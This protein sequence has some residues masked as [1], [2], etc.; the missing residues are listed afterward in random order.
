VDGFIIVPSENSSGQIQNLV[1]KNIPFVLIDRYFPEINTSHIVLD[2]YQA[3][4][5][6]TSHLINEGY[7]RISMV[8]YKS[9]LIHMK[10]RIRGYREAMESHNLDEHIKVA[11][12]RYSNSREDIESMFNKFVLE[13]KNNHAF[14]FA[15]NALSI[16]GL[17]CIQKKCLK[18]PEDI[19]FI[20]F[21]GGESF[22]LF[23]PPLSFIQQ[24]LEEMAKEAFGVLM[25]L[26]NGSSKII[27]VRLSPTLI[28][29]KSNKC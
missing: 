6:A 22:D 27:Q 1:R 24:P 4:F 16:A 18:I 15:T 5:D 11:E 9:S 20:G 3:T 8:A 29:R 25:S 17:Y 2:N 14:L 10:E 7:R 19:A 13:K 26:I 23:S 28:I 21:D 12:I